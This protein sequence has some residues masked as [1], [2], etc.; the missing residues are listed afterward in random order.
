MPR[1]C[2]SVDYD[3]HFDA[4]HARGDLLDY[5][6]NGADGSTRR[7]LDALIGEGVAGASLLDIG[8]GVGIVELELLEAGVASSVDVDASGP[9]LAVAE[10]E[11]AERGFGDRTA[12]WHGDFVA[13]ADEI[14][15]ADVVTLDRVICCY[16]DVRSLVSRS[17]QH[18]QQLFGLVYPVDRWWTRSGIWIM[19]L[20]TRISRND[21]RAYVHSA[22][23]VDRLIRD[24]GLELRYHH[25]GWVWQTA[26]YARPSSSGNGGGRYSTEPIGSSSSA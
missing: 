2:C 3:V 11:A 16:R 21:Y 10:S 15:A 26:V 17:A 9:Y 25:R 1:D 13:M 23:L 12:Y 5:R 8:G 14:E 22:R 19:N 4:E 20:I 24:A 6:A 7:L 18:A